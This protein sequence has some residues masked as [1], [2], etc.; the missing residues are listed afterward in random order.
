VD[1]PEKPPDVILGDPVSASR[2]L[3]K[4]VIVPVELHAYDEPLDRLHDIGS[5]KARKHPIVIWLGGSACREHETNRFL[6]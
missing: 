6:P 5:S 3:A 1:V 4:P 2:P